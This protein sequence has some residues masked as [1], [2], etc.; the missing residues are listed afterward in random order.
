MSK[1]IFSFLLLLLASKILFA[2]NQSKI[3][4]LKQ[5][6]E[7][8]LSDKE[9]VDIYVMIAGEYKNID[10][11][12]TFQYIDKAI[13]LADEINY[14]EGK[15]DALRKLG[16]QHVLLGNY[17]KAEA[18]FHEIIRGSREIKYKK[19]KALGYEGLGVLFMSQGDYEKALDYYFKS[20]KINE[21]F[22]NKR[23][24]ASNYN[25]IG[26]IYNKQG[27]YEK[28]LDYYF[29][30][31]KINEKNDDKK[32]IAIN[33]NNLGLI[34]YYQGD[35]EKALDYY[36]KSLKIFEELKNKEGLSSNY[37]RTGYIYEEE[38]NYRKALDYYFKSLKIF[39]EI[40]EKEG[41][42]GTYISVATIYF[43]QENYEKSLNYFFK[44]LKIFET[45]DD[46]EGIASAYNNIG[47]VYQEQRDYEKSLNYYLKSSK[48]Q[49]ELSNKLGIA[50]TYTNIGSIYG[51]QENYKEAL[52]Y[53]SRSLEM[54]K[55][56]N[57]KVD[58]SFCLIQISMVYRK[59]KKWNS[60]KNYL[61]EALEL[62]QETG[63]IRHIRDATEQ[64][65]LVEKELGNYH[66]A[67]EYQV[68]FKQMADSLQNEEQTKNITRLEMNYEFEQEK[69]SIQFANEAEQLVL[70]KD[71]ENRKIIQRSTF[72]GL[73]LLAVLAV[74]LFIFFQSKR[75]SNRLLTEKTEQLE[76]ANEEIKTINEE[77][78]ITNEELKTANESINRQNVE[79]K[80]L[81]DVKNKLFSIISH[82]LRGPLGN[83]LSVLE[84]MVERKV[85]EEE[86]KNILEHLKTETGEVSTLFDNLLYW[87]KSQ[88]E[89]GIEANP[90]EID[91]S[92]LVNDNVNLIHN[93]AQNKGIQI[94][95]QVEGEN[96]VYADKDMIKLIIRNILHNAL[97]FSSEGKNIYLSTAEKE[98]FVTLKIQDE[99]MGM[100]PET[101]EILFQPKTTQ[102]SPE[103][104][105]SGKGTGLGL[106]L[107]QEFI[108]KNKGEITVESKMG[109][110][111]TFYIKLPKL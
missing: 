97:K 15:I 59:Q 91:L 39:E 38:G 29:K 37:Q 26:L 70:E 54:H 4:S 17:A 48:L 72:I 6:L 24:I 93:R 102:L 28:A 2:Q 57:A 98:D 21:E 25:Y 31:L 11:L 68:L 81:N 80:E 69:D 45:L 92:K 99:G 58:K 53:L 27:D 7:S 14:P 111:S 104:T 20:L 50:V 42:A 55:T 64:L 83:I 40:G 10:S 34:Y 22:N 12:N 110:G 61:N 76:V 86:A 13:G 74:V 90:R 19:G 52:K 71:I 85:P 33:Y 67:Y 18:I 65:A 8:S 79:L 100:S 94:I 82:D 46:K 107:S 62:A 60:A 73:A 96:K 78:T 75:R 109:E 105:Q 108:E 30:S 5:I 101:V 66:A 47:V 49:E 43:F 3:D 32:G 87:A 9:R 56:L 88:M 36:F 95:N 23:L 44:S 16:M 106:M 1:I 84:L 103:H 63:V 77:V 89:K 41:I 51:R 35:Y